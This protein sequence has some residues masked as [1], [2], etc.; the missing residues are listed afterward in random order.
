MNSGRWSGG[1]CPPVAIE[2]ELAG[3][4]A[5]EPEAHELRA[6]RPGYAGSFHVLANQRTAGALPRVY[7]RIED[8][9]VDDA[10]GGRRWVAT[11]QQE[12]PAQKQPV[13]GFDSIGHASKPNAYG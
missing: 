7:A 11:T 13:E 1:E 6:V 9:L 12:T 5:E 3:A 2:A 4:G 8:D 10:A